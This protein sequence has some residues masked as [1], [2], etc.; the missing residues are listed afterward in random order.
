MGWD[1]NPRWAA[2]TPVF[3]TGALNR[4]AT[5]PIAETPVPIRRVEWFTRQCSRCAC[6]VLLWQPP[7]GGAAALGANGYVRELPERWLLARGNPLT[8][9]TLSPRG[10]IGR[11]K[12]SDTRSPITNIAKE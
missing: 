1:S 6:G 3:K 4:S 11:A 7:P 5:H 8:A 12:L 2:P 10:S 9:D